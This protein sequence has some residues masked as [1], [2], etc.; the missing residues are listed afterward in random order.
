LE[1]IG[2]I[3]RATKFYTQNRHLNALFEHMAT[4]VGYVSDEYL[5]LPL[6]HRKNKWLER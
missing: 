2:K 3:I 5:G 1:V 4:G 6:Y